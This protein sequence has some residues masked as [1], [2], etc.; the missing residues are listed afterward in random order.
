MVEP[1]PP[2]LRLR[3]G[4]D[5]SMAGVKVE[6]DEALRVG[7]AIT[8]VEAPKTS[9]LC[10]WSGNQPLEARQLTPPLSC[11]PLVRALY[12][13]S[14]DAYVDVETDSF[15]LSSPTCS[16]TFAVIKQ[17]RTRSNGHKRPK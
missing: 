8:S 17:S 13:S 3:S 4:G 12:E 1:A 2:V 11:S 16:T 10:D 5:V 7:G 14:H 6:Q 9:P 15:G